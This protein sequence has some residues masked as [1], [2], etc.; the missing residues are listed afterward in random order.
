MHKQ[1]TITNPQEEQ[2]HQTALFLCLLVLL[3]VVVVIVHWPVLSAKVLSFDDDQYLTANHL[4]Q[5]PSW[6]SAKRFMSEVFKPST[7]GGYYQPLTMISLML[8]Y[9]VAGDVKNLRPFHGTSLGLHAANTILVAVILYV[10]FGNAWIA[11]ICGLLFGLHPMTV[12]PMAWIS[13]RKTLLASFFAFLSLLS[14]VSYAKAKKR[15]VWLYFSALLAYTLSLLSKPTPIALPLLFILLDW[16]PLKRVSLKTLLEKIPF[17]IIAILSAIVTFVSQSTV[18]P[19]NIAGGYGIQN[20]WLML[21]HNIIFYPAKIIW[22]VNLSSFYPFPEPFDLSNPV[23]IISV[24]GTVIL[25][26]VLVLSTRWTKAFLVGWL[27]FFV[28]ALPTMQIVQFS[29]VIASDKFAY[30][31][32]FGFLLSLAFVL[33]V[34]WDKGKVAFKVL[35][36]LGTVIIAP[37]EVKATRG[38]LAH[39][40]NPVGY[41]EYMLAQ[42]P[43]DVGIHYLLGNALRDQGRLVEAEANYQIVL[44]KEPNN[45]WNH[46]NYGII[47]AQLGR[48]DEAI[49]NFEKAVS[50][51]PEFTEA[52]YNLGNALRLKGD[53][54]GAIAEYE[55]TLEYDEE[56]IKAYNNLGGIYMAQNK[57]DKAISSFRQAIHYSP[58][59]EQAHN[60]LG[61]ALMKK[62]QFDQ[63]VIQFRKALEIK[64]DYPSARANLA[65]ALQLQKSQLQQTPKSE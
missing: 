54:A 37:A 28:A 22:P 11:V 38:Y 24:I 35:I 30:L 34:V 5:N 43:G 41:F 47:L 42:T 7:V 21:C 61:L 15:A 8:D 20:I 16:W 26:S 39:W 45:P 63:A 49:I 52:H 3:A 12:E 29:N 36:I 14:Y 19:P 53:F 10:I 60:N 65:K 27:F 25:L 57:L 46:N 58:N 6:R 2:K 64:P 9:S 17:I 32:S 4:V 62:G 18:S 13:E 44:A 56:Y 33:K 23:L 59:Y 1:D 48:L 40:K 55:K 51:M 50:V 31:P